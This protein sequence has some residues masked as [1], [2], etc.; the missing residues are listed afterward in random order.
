MTESRDIFFLKTELAKMDNENG[1]LIQHPL[2]PSKMKLNP[3]KSGK[4]KLIPLHK[5]KEASIKYKHLLPKQNNVIS[6][7]YESLIQIVLKIFKNSNL[8]TDN[9]KMEHIKTEQMTDS[10]LSQNSNNDKLNELLF[11]L[12][13]ILPAIVKI[14]HQS[15]ININHT[16]SD[17][18]PNINSEK[19]P[20][21]IKEYE[22]FLIED[23]KH[24]TCESQNPSTKEQQFSASI[25]STQMTKALLSTLSPN[26]KEHMI[27]CL[28]SSKQI[29]KTIVNK[30]NFRVNP[31]NTTDIKKDFKMKPICFKDTMEDLNETKGERPYACSW[32]DCVWRFP[33]LDELNRH[34]RTHT[35]ERPFKC[36]ICE[37]RFTRAD[38][39][40]CHIKR[41]VFAILAKIIC[42]HHGGSGLN[43][44]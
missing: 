43:L 21:N 31:Q 19:Y 44:N 3:E 41:H 36:H 28:L 2:R 10:N 35:G 33:R 9:N 34:F 1:E 15:H 6:L 11:K 23:L 5:I 40:R 30:N 24:K 14:L 22:P 42:F 25:L 29:N 12:N 8:F 17:N 16:R 39:M 32:P 38:H 20:T 26:N 37:K 18:F 4:I 7:D 27:S 13:I